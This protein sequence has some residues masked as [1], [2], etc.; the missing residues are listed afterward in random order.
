MK[1]YLL[2]V[3]YDGEYMYLYNSSTDLLHDWACSSFQ[4][5]LDKSNSRISYTIYEVTDIYSN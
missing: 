1:K 5:L 3:S 2:V 4:E